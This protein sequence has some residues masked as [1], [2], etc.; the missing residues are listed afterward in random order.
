VAAFPFA[1]RGAHDIAATHVSAAAAHTKLAGSE[2]STIWVAT[3]QALVAL[4][5]GDSQR[6]AD[7][8]A[9]LW[10][11]PAW[12]AA[13]ETG[14][15]FRPVM[16]AEALVALG[17]CDQAQAIVDSFE[18][19]AMARGR[20]S[21]QAAAARARGTLEAALG[22]YERAETAYQTG[23]NLV[24]DL[25][26]PFER[27]LFEAAYACFLRHTGRRT[28]AAAQLQAARGRLV[29]LQAQPYLQR[30]DHDLAACAH[31]PTRRQPERRPT[32]TPQ[33]QAVARLVAAGRSNR[34]A[35]AELFVS[36]KTIEYHLSNAFAK[37]AVTSRTQLALALH[38]D[39]G[40]P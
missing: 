12:T 27:A 16:H 4:A 35:A 15:Q 10:R 38:Q 25:P 37:L 29:A 19:H 14:G 6:V 17:R 34:Q 18:T 21:A 28:E 36:V 30:C 26:L 3:A 2:Y 13:D 5:E 40:N 8:F 31:L 23:L 20:R 32:L 22:H 9:P 33:E 39:S 1:A 24:G 7:A 11:L